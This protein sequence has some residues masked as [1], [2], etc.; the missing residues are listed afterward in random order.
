MRISDWSS[1]VCSS[2]LYYGGG[3]SAARALAANDFM[4][5]AVM[6]RAV[7]ERGCTLFDFGRSKVGTGPFS[8]KKNW[9]FEPEPLFYEFRLGDGAMMPDIN[10]L[11]PKYRLMVE[12]WK[13]GRASCRERECQ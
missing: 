4:Y 5:W 11:N 7:E 1:D 6:R 12:T 10:Q 13:I 9:G 3:T 8:F 2:D